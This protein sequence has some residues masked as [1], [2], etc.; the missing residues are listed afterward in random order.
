MPAV[1]CTLPL[2][3]PFTERVSPAASLRVLGRIPDHTDLC[4]ALH[5]GAVDVLCPQLADRV[6]AAVLD[7]G[8]PTLR[9]VC[10][11]AVGY[12]NVDVAAATERGIAIGHT[13]G[14]L[15]DAT[16]D[17]TMALL[18]AAARR[19][20]EGDAALRAGE[21]RGWEPG[22]LLG[23]ELSGALLGIVGFGR[24]GQAVARRARGFGMRLAAHGHHGVQ[25]PDDLA[26]SVQIFDDLGALLAESDVVSLHMPLTAETHHLIDEEALRRMKP[27]AILINAARGPVVDEHALVQALREGWIAGCGLDVYESEPELTPGLAECRNAVLAPHL[28]SATV[29]TRAAMA[30]LTAANVLAVLAGDLPVHCVN[31]A[32]AAVRR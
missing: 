32:V 22:Y 11:Y 8:L 3:D 26:G 24:I 15:T 23:M 19:L 1:L 12:N 6:D 5:E 28:G 2:P 27:T 29:R 25:V 7:A 14:V 16:A 17:L 21:F 4:A 18:L 9:G 20:V 13:P 31:P 30:E 10:V